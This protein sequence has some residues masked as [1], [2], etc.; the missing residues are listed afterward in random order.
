MMYRM[1][2]IPED[3]DKEYRIH[4]ETVVDAYGEEELP[5]RR[6]SNGLVLLHG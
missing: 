1:D 4:D 3:A 6:A 5:R 2:R